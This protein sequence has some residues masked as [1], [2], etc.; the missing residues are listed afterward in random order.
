MA[1]VA[2]ASAGAAP[3]CPISYG[4][5]DDAKPNKLY[6]YYPTVADATFPEFGGGRRRPDI[7]G[8]PRSTPAC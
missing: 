6:L 4:S 1:L 7:A 2:P 5:A 8:R 3:A